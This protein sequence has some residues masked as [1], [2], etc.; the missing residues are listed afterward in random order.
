FFGADYSTPKATIGIAKPYVTGH[1]GQVV[2]ESY[3]PMGTAD[4]SQDITN[5]VNAHP[6]VA[7]LNVVGND[8]VTLQKQW[9]A[10]PRTKG[11]TRVDILLGEGP[12]HALGNAAEGI[13]SSN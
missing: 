4:Y 8:D 1:G 13:W 11:I 5:I 10:D 9:A 3:E 6:D 2:G 7:F 12:A